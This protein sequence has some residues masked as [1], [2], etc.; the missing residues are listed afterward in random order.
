[1]AT[2]CS[3]QE[4]YVPA[5]LC[6][7]ARSDDFEEDAST[8]A[9]SD[10]P[11]ETE[12]EC[13]SEVAKLDDFDARISSKSK[14]RTRWA[15]LEDSDEEAAGSAMGCRRQ[16]MPSAA[17]SGLT[18]EDLAC[19]AEKGDEGGFDFALVEG[20]VSSCCA[21]VQQQAR[22]EVQPQA[23]AEVYQEQL[24]Q[25]HDETWR[26]WG[27]HTAWAESWAGA[28]PEVRSAQRPAG[29]NGQR[30]SPGHSSKWWAQRWD[31]EDSQCW[32]GSS[33]Q[34]EWQPQRWDTRH[35]KA[36]RGDRRGSLTGV[37]KP[38]C[39]FYV[40]IEEEPKFRV[41][42]KLL[43]PHGQHVKAIAEKTWAKLRLRGLGSGFLEGPEQQESTDELML[44]VSAQDA[45][46][47]AEAV[48]LVTELLEGVHEQYRAHLRKAGQ[49]PPELSVRIHEGPRP[50]S[51]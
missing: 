36:Q 33:V 5:N 21:E 16:A 30:A 9:S 35:A 8:E 44:C 31:T 19:A 6:H 45:A 43:G 22:A 50:G 13:L 49:S 3:S 28:A 17:S 40:G 4:P 24:L 41:T 20:S 27:R 15:D 26:T 14:G 32:A 39:Q 38:Q 1:M 51:R 18:P 25:V 23:S 47:Y 37:A 29:H 7:C 10:P 48:K 12:R 46:S 11:D 42:R 34:Q 2:A